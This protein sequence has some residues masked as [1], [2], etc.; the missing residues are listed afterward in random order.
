MAVMSFH[1]DQHVTSENFQ[2]ALKQSGTGA[3]DGS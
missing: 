2:Q 1:A 3:R